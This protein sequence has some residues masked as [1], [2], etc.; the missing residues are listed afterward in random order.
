[1]EEVKTMEESAQPSENKREM[2]NA[3]FARE[4]QRYIKMKKENNEVLELDVR[5]ME[6]QVKQYELSKQIKKINDEIKELKA[7]EEFKASVK[8]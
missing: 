1:M 8:I 4:R 2:T 7:S 6:L 3:E 5:S